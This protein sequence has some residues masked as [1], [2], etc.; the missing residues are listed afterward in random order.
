VTVIQGDL[1][2]L[3]TLQNLLVTDCVVV[4]L[5]YGFNM[6][7]EDNLLATKN[8][9]EICKS[10]KIKRLI[11]CSTASVFGRNFD[12]IVNEESVCYPVTEY[13][14]TKLSIEQI[15]L[16]ESRG[17][18]EFVNL[19]PTSVFGPDG[20]ALAK[21]I[22]RLTQGSM[23]INYL[24]SCLFN[25]RKL[26]L[27]SVETVTASI[28]FMMS[29][30]LKVD[31]HTFIVSEDYESINNFHDVEQYLLNKLVGKYYVF[32]PLNIPLEILSF[33]LRICGRDVYNPSRIY[34]SRKILEIGF[35]PD[36]TLQQSLDAFIEWHKAQHIIDKNKQA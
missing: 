10:G 34:D 13:G 29:P 30:K 35:H 8:L 18:F 2:K 19:R 31:G 22:N 36:K 21:L 9:A 5:A 15:L 4:N 12:D 11:H 17:N 7:S 26:N 33:I 25:K 6:S 3:E 27:V 32:R 28:I 20:Q 16:D 14:V 1:T 24:R 23:M